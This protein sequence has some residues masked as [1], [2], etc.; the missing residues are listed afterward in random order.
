MESSLLQISDFKVERNRRDFWYRKFPY[1]LNIYVNGTQY[2]RNC[3]NEQHYNNFYAEKINNRLGIEAYQKLLTL[4]VLKQQFQDNDKL[5]FTISW[6]T[7][8]VYAETLE[9]ISAVYNHM[10]AVDNFRFDLYRVDKLPD[11]DPEKVYLKNPT[12]AIR[13]YFNSF[14]WNLEDRRRLREY[15]YNSDPRIKVSPS[16]REWFVRMKQ[17]STVYT[18][19]KMFVDLN[20]EQQITYMGIAF[21]GLIRKVCKIEKG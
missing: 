15:C 5:K 11:Y 20:D 2:I 9:D 18:W 4:V 19:T 6:G 10:I 12:H 14:S 21:P 7:L 3:K 13:I 16:L 8:S 1:R 17:Y